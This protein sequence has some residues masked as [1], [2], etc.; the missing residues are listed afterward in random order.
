[1]FLGIDIIDIIKMTKLSIHPGKTFK[2]VR[3]PN[4][5]PMAI[6]SGTVKIF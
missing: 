6:L 5:I 4:S 2:L 3:E 1:M